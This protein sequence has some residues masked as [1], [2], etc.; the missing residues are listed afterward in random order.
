MD[1]V[2]SFYH[3]TSRHRASTPPTSGFH[4]R[5]HQGSDDA[6]FPPHLRSSSPISSIHINNGPRLGPTDLSPVRWKPKDEGHNPS[7]GGG[8]LSG[9]NSSDYRKYSSSGPATTA[10]GRTNSGD[11]TTT[12]TQQ[13]KS[14]ATLPVGWRPASV[15]FDNVVQH[16]LW[17]LDDHCNASQ[18]VSSSSITSSQKQ[19]SSA[20][21]HAR[22]ASPD[23]FTNTHHNNGF[24]SDSA[25]TQRPASGDP[26]VRVYQ[27]RASMQ[28]Q[29]RLKGGI[30][31]L[32]NSVGQQQQYVSSPARSSSFSGLSAANRAA[33]PSSSNASS[34][35]APHQQQQ[36]APSLS[37]FTIGA[38]LLPP[39]H[40]VVISG[41]QQTSPVLSGRSANNSTSSFPTAAQL[42]RPVTP[43]GPMSAQQRIAN[44]AARIAA[45]ATELGSASVEQSSGLQRLL[46]QK[47]QE[48][49]DLAIAILSDRHA[50]AESSAPPLAKLP[51]GVH[52]RP[53]HSAVDAMSA[54]P[55]TSAVSLRHSTS[56]SQNL[57]GGTSSSFGGAMGTYGKM[58]DSVG[59]FTLR[60]GGGAD[61]ISSSVHNMSA[62]FEQQGKHTMTRRSSPPTKSLF[63]PE[64]S[65]LDATSSLN[66]TFTSSKKQGSFAFGGT[67]NR[68][69]PGRTQAQENQQPARRGTAVTFAQQA[70]DDGSGDDSNKP[71]QREDEGNTNS[72]LDMSLPDEFLFTH[73][74]TNEEVLL[75][76]ELAG[77]DG[78]MGDAS[79]TGD[80]WAFEHH[81]IRAS[82]KAGLLE[83]A[84]LSQQQQQ[85]QQQSAGRRQS[86][87]ATRLG[88]GDGGDRRRSSAARP[89]QTFLDDTISMSSSAKLVP[90][91]ARRRRSSNYGSGNGDDG[92]NELLSAQVVP[93]HMRESKILERKL[94]ALERSAAAFAMPQI[95]LEAFD[96]G[97]PTF[98]DRLRR[99]SSPLDPTSTTTA[100]SEEGGVG[101]P[102]FDNTQSGGTDDIEELASPNEGEEGAAAGGN[103]SAQ[104]PSKIVLFDGKGVASSSN[105]N[106]QKPPIGIERRIAGGGGATALAVRTTSSPAS[107]TT[108][109]APLLI[110]TTSAGELPQGTIALRSTPRT[111]SIVDFFGKK[112]KTVIPEG[113]TFIPSNELHLYQLYCLNTNM[114]LIFRPVSP[115]VPPM[116]AGNFFVPPQFCDEDGIPLMINE[117]NQRLTLQEVL[118]FTVAECRVKGKG[119]GVSLK[120]SPYPPI[121]GFIPIN[122]S[123]SKTYSEARKKERALE[124]NMINQAAG[125]GDAMSTAL[126]RKMRS[127]KSLFSAAT[128]VA[129][130]EIAASL[131]DSDQ[132]LATL[133]DAYRR[134]SSY[135][136]DKLA[137][138]EEYIGVLNETQFLGKTIATWRGMQVYYKQLAGDADVERRENAHPIFY[139]LK[140][141][142]LFAYDLERNE[143]ELSR[144]YPATAE[145]MEIVYH[146]VYILT[147]RSFVISPISKRIEP[148]PLGD[149]L[150]GPDFDG[151]AYAANIVTGNTSTVSA[152]RSFADEQIM[153]LRVLPTMGL[154]N[155]IDIDHILEMRR[156]TEWKQSHGYECS[157]TLKTQDISDGPHVIV[158][159]NEVR[160]A[161]NF[162]EL[163]TFYREAW[164]CGYPLLLNPN[165]RVV[166]CPVERLPVTLGDELSLP[167]IDDCGLALLKHY[168][169]S[170]GKKFDDIKDD[171]VKYIDELVAL[172]RQGVTRLRVAGMY[173]TSLIPRV[174][175][176]VARKKLADYFYKLRRW[177]LFPPLFE[178]DKLNDFDDDGTSPN[179][180][181]LRGATPSSRALTRKTSSVFTAGRGGRRAATVPVNAS[182]EAYRE[183]KVSE[184]R[185]VFEEECA[186]FDAL[187]GSDDPRFVRRLKHFIDPAVAA[188]A[189]LDANSSKREEPVSDGAASFLNPNSVEDPSKSSDR[190]AGLSAI[191]GAL[192]ASPPAA[193]AGAGGTTTLAGATRSLSL[194]AGAQQGGGQQPVGFRRASGGGP[195]P[196]AKKFLTSVAADGERPFAA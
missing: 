121:D 158:M 147:H 4:H 67:G 39:R 190:G 19:I 61:N 80:M 42:L 53:S 47:K 153:N 107:N 179:L 102:S 154:V 101:S 155:D 91:N 63:S 59:G 29:Q 194:S 187:F 166:L 149:F 97:S 139:C 171:A 112:A 5:S 77:T 184:L 86:V 6:V 10:A 181:S 26:L 196:S 119:I 21:L 74:L 129:M 32:D 157:N 175:V 15:E 183:Q 172:R 185:A 89:S 131:K 126:L 148:D 104:R 140:G 37:S 163:M 78:I 114:I 189:S 87:S 55:P 145:T 191:L 92:D 141:T 164:Q 136:I 170:V 34:F 25:F 109:G 118:G 44:A 128:S 84:L 177:M 68:Q 69:S 52:Q 167:I 161:N 7:A 79:I 70:P 168:L 66:A 160:L 188:Q 152:Y 115:S 134:Q 76:A 103:R 71:Q 20:A 38:G 94:R 33:T 151:F 106:S 24:G 125:G 120:S 100:G 173:S 146:P 82:A 138:A 12:T 176:V 159:P 41:A 48:E 17:L 73:L 75:L 169:S 116:Y 49:E 143:L 3:V 11:T 50:A 72:N 46:R 36:A 58:T 111:Q 93:L 85:Q 14:A 30:S 144:S 127:Q 2:E 150:I 83:E 105:H 135:A 16:R 180:D 193:G 28:R 133:L 90:P 62:S 60:S 1:R 122:P 35:L 56:S 137:V 162:P 22:S 142:E 31:A 113:D 27:A 182:F 110:N 96:V 117:I 51:K 88:G 23:T 45:V 132:R 186:V 178:A 130:K 8:A 13:S 43:A 124:D 195:P 18:V 174:A 54:L 192:P 95:S 65:S 165:W 9:E 81:E 156:L 98:Q 57:D 99:K 64:S 108:S 123:L 40:S